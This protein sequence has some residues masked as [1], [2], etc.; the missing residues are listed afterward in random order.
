MF[1]FILIE[2]LCASCS[3]ISVSFCRFGKF[4]A[5]ISSNTFSITFSSPSGIPIKYRLGCFILS[6]RYHILLSFFFSFSFFFLCC[7]DWVISIF[8]SSSSLIHSSAL[9][10]LLFIAFSSAFVP[11][12]E[13]SNFNW[14][15]FIVSNSLL[16]WLAFLSIA[17]LIP[18]VFLLLPF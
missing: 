11:E 13:F 4:S 5:I 17:F 12:N 6:H 1:G 14:L 18:S 15:L 2:T 9:S 16:Q 7:S 10:S 8:L 3:Q